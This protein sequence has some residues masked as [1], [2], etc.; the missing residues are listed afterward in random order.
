MVGMVC[1][2]SWSSLF[3][4]QTQEPG[5]NETM[6]ETTGLLLLPTGDVMVSKQ[7]CAM[8]AP[9]GVQPL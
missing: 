9:S 1:P 3:G 2:K 5:P 6:G 8:G 4:F 7:T